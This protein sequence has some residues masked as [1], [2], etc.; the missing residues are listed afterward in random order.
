MKKNKF[1]LHIDTTKDDETDTGLMVEYDKEN[2]LFRVSYFKEN[3][4]QEQVVFHKN[5]E[6]NEEWWC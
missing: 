1:I 3:H 6:D 4:F 5:I 2:E